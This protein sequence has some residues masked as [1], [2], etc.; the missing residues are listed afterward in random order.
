MTPVT[1]PQ[2]AWA[3]HGPLTQGRCAV[4]TGPPPAMRSGHWEAGEEPGPSQGCRRLL[5]PRARA[6]APDPAGGTDAQMLWRV[7]PHH[8]PATRGDAGSSPGRSGQTAPAGDSKSESR[9][10]LWDGG[11]RRGQGHSYMPARR[12]WVRAGGPRPREHTRLTSARPRP[13]QRSPCPPRALARHS[14]PGARA[15]RARSRPAPT[16]R[17]HGAQVA[18]GS[19][20]PPGSSL[21]RPHGHCSRLGRAPL[22]APTSGELPALFFWGSSI[23]SGPAPLAGAPRTPF[24]DRLHSVMSQSLA[25]ITGTDQAQGWGDCGQVWV[26]SLSGGGPVQATQPYRAWWTLWQVPPP[27]H[28]DSGDPGC[29]PFYT[30]LDTRAPPP[31]G[32]HSCSGAW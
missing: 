23:L 22:P 4:T 5:T 15:S 12:V 18:P 26:A 17:G 19:C 6:A 32:A 1:P 30:A 9:T 28:L 3:P 13:R 16:P 29:S 7:P 14:P 21:S 25:D 2:C 20:R 24:S 10:G 11:P 27:W 8:P 31:V